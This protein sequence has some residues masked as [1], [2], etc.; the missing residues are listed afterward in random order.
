MRRAR[1]S[2]SL[3]ASPLFGDGG[4]AA[5]L[6]LAAASGLSLTALGGAEPIALFP[7]RG[8]AFGL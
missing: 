5:F 4:L 7:R 1:A 8:F 3:F 6:G 2:R